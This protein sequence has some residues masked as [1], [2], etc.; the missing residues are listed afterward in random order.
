MDAIL[1]QIATFLLSLIYLI[2]MEQYPAPQSLP[3]ITPTPQILGKQTEVSPKDTVLKQPAYASPAIVSR[4][5]DGDTVKVFLNNE[6]VTVRLIGI[7][8]PE[9][10]EKRAQIECFG[11]EASERAKILLTGKNIYLEPDESQ[12]DKDRYGRLLRYIWL[13]DG[14]N[15]NEKMIAEGY[16]YEYT[17][18][19]PYKYQKE[20]KTAQINAQQ[21]KVGLWAD[22]TC[23]G[24]K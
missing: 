2:V 10:D 20:F 12:L 9:I 4:V 14:T 19:V 23:R 11:L 6:T 5:I 7:D 17:Y 15:I 21:N 8:T 24:G 13:D 16:A 22:T 18:D 1:Q 3:V